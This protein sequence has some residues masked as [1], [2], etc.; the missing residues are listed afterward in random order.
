MLQLG[1]NNVLVKTLTIYD[2][3]SSEHYN[4][5]SGKKALTDV[6]HR[7]VSDRTKRETIPARQLVQRE[8]GIKQTTLQT[9]DA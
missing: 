7:T 2:D 6:L 1:E 3:E 5:Y 9:P 4:T 8:I